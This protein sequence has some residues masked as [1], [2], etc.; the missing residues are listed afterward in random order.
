MRN[1]KKL[2]YAA[3]QRAKKDGTPFALVESDLRIPERC[4]VLGI[5]LKRSEGGPRDGSP[6]LDRFVP[7]RGYIPGNVHV[8]SFRANSIKGTYSTEQLRSGIA[9]A[10]LYDSELHEWEAVLRWMETVEL[11]F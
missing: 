4:P 8:I 2:L 5:E 6:S 9:I 1:M 10:K 7:Q 11:L 3:K